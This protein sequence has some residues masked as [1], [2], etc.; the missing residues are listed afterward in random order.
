MMDESKLPWLVRFFLAKAD[1]GMYLAPNELMSVQMIR[2][3]FG[4][5]SQPVKR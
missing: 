2:N 4:C 1:A 5:S 3:G